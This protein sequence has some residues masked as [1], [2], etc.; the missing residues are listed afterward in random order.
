MGRREF[1]IS[2]AAIV[3]ARNGAAREE[4]RAMYG[5]IG[6]FTAAAGKRDELIAILIS[7]VAA[8]PGCI[9]YIVA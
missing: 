7:A 2:S 5:S 8:M 9:S 6:N 1:L 4:T 3:A